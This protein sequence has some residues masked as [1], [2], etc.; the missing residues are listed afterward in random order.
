[1]GLAN[2][3]RLQTE[4]RCDLWNFV[5]YEWREYELE[6]FENSIAGEQTGAHGPKK[7]WAPRERINK[8]LRRISGDAL[9]HKVVFETHNQFS[10]KFLRVMNGSRLRGYFQSWKYVEP[11]ADLLHSQLMSPRNPSAW[12]Q[13][14]LSELSSGEP[15]IGVHV[16]LGDYQNLPAM[17]V[18]GD[19][20]YRRA[21][22]LLRKL[23]HHHKVVVFT[24][25]PSVVRQ[26]SLFD[27]ET[28]FSI[29]SESGAKSSL[30]TLLLMAQASHLVT[31]NSTFSWWAGWLGRENRERTVI[32][33]RPWLNIRSWDD[34]DL[35]MPHWVGLSRE[36]TSAE[37]AEL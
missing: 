16:R 14:K 4:L 31:A 26:R 8:R 25:S 21:I 3:V 13:K 7:Y 17:G 5:G 24:D 20:Y 33:P 9:G 23:G 2:A 22:K 37:D 15:W 11:V 12:F 28:N 30:E 36:T 18:A 6:S 35:P 10:P 34:R 1:M 32:F 19:V 29:L 27:E